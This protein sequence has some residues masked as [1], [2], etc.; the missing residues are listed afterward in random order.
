[1]R[2][3]FCTFLTLGL[4]FMGGCQLAGDTMDLLDEKIEVVNVSISNG[5]GEMNEDITFSF[6]DNK[7]IKI[8]EN[9]IKSAV[10]HDSEI[11]KTKPDY[12]VMVN[13]GEGFPVHAIHLWLGAENEQSTLM[14]L[15][16]EGQTYI[17]SSKYTN[18][19]RELLLQEQ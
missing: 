8:F 3:L 7:S 14:Y 13:Y 4:F 15:V 11:N 12:D 18:Q 17:T 10:E 6:D 1:M 2:K 16:G 5:A 9:A 19:L